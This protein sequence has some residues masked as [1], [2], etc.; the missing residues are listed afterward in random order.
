MHYSEKYG[1]NSEKSNKS[2][3]SKHSELPTFNDAMTTDPNQELKTPS[4]HFSSKYGKNLKKIDKKNLLTF[5]EVMT[6]QNQELNP[7][8]VHFS[9]NMAKNH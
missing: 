8:S 5:N 2:I 9:E 7:P 1:K 6:D 4:V 3:K